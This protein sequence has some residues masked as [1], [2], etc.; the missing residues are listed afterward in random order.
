MLRQAW[1]LLLGNGRQFVNLD[2][3]YNRRD[4][5]RAFVLPMAA[6]LSVLKFLSVL[7]FRSNLQAAIVGLIFTFIAFLSLY[8]L[9]ALFSEWLVRAMTG[10]SDAMGRGHVFALQ[11][12]MLH[13]DISLLFDLFPSFGFLSLLYLASFY[14]AWHLGRRYLAIPERRTIWFTIIIS[15][16]FFVLV[17]AVDAAL[18]LM[19]PNNPL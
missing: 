8:L 3:A 10:V 17:H 2:S 5:I 4:K 15:V 16:V 11:L 6:M 1:D 19:L 14:I 12:M 18:N 7:L 13:F 9:T